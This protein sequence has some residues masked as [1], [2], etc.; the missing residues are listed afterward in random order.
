MGEHSAAR[1]VDRERVTAERGRATSLRDV[2]ERRDI[3]GGA[4][5][6]R[7][8]ARRRGDALEHARQQLAVAHGAYRNTTVASTW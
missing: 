2:G 7:A 4:H 3:D 1:V 5:D 6:E 8:H